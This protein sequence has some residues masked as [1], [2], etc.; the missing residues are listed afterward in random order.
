M[1][2]GTDDNYISEVGDVFV[3]DDHVFNSIGRWMTYNNS[4]E[5][6]FKFFS[7]KSIDNIELAKIFHKGYKRI[8]Q[9]FWFAYPKYPK[10]ATFNDIILDEGL[11]YVNSIEAGTS[12]MEVMDVIQS[13]FQ[14]EIRN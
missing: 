9:T 6:I 4:K 10:K 1:Y 12:A 13:N 14:F 3:A 8:Y 7:T 2:F 5:A 11:Y